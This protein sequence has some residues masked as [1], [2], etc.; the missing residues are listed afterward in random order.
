VGHTGGGFTRA[1]LAEMYKTLHPLEQKSSPFE[2]TPRTNEKA[3]W[4]RP[5]IVVEVKF[6]EWTSDR[7]LRQPIYLGVRDDKRAKDVGRE[8]SSVQR[9]PSKTA[10]KRKPVAARATRK[11]AVSKKPAVAPVQKQAASRQSSASSGIVAQLEEIEQSRGEGSVEFGKGRS[12]DVSNLGKIYF[13]KE[14]IS[15]G[16]LMR[17]Y[18]SVADF[19]LPTL[20]DRPLVLKRFPSGIE[21][22]SFYQQNAGEKVAPHV[23]VERITSDA[24]ERQDRFVGGDLLTLLYTVQLGAIS[25]DPWHSRIGTLDFADYTIVDLDPGPRAN[26]SRVMDVARWCKEV[27]DGFKLSAA[28][29]TSGSTGLHI[30]MPLPPKTPTDAA[31]L[32]AQVIAT[33]V[34]EKHPREAT[35]ERAVKA[36]GVSIVYVDYLQNIKGKTIAGAYCVRAKP[37]APVSTPLSWEELG[38]GLDPRDFTIATVP[39][40][41]RKTGDLWGPAMHKKN[42]LKAL[43]ER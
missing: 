31:T 29:K 18:A 30:Y 12:L 11:T 36:R 34:A 43:L 39:D 14:R 10:A 16:D 41:L 37:G 8:G 42:S 24:G 38:E 28:I 25:V 4:V 32:V 3:H 6:S 35:I 26:F 2:E 21:G 1:G 20:R 7:R 23:R 27:I 13:P 22:Q 5:K 33:R 15:K 40:R 9:K 17:Y 19:I